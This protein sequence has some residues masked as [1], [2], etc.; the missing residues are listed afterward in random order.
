VSAFPSYAD[1]YSR[2]VARPAPWAG[3]VLATALA[4][5]SPTARAEQPYP[6]DV[7]TA[8]GKPDLVETKM[9]PPMGCQL[10][11]TDPTGGTTTLTLF[12][13]YLVSEYDFPKIAVIQD[14]Q[15]AQ[16]LAK[17]KAGQPE[18]WAHMQAGVDPNTDPLLTENAPPQPAYGCS[19]GASGGSTGPAWA[20][21]LGLFAFAAFARS[22]GGRGRA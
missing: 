22:R 4:V 2:S 1:S 20:G 15:L 8:L 16:V 17:L 19:A 10:C 21:L 18:L 6:A 13:N 9:D 3:V 7:D 11:H 5:W 14:A 12:G